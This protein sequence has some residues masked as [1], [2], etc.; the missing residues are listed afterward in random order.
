MT[1]SLNPLYLI[2]LAFLGCNSPDESF[3]NGIADA[4]EFLRKEDEM[5]RKEYILSYQAAL[6]SDRNLQHR[7]AYL[8]L[9]S[10]ITSSSHYMDSIYGE[11]SFQA[12]HNPTNFEY[13]KILFLYKGVGDSIFAGLT[14][15]NDLARTIALQT[16]HLSITD[17]LKLTVLSEPV[18]S[19]WKE[20]YFSELNPVSAMAF[21]HDFTCEVF[22]VGKACL[23]NP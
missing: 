8:H 21:V 6:R 16:C 7:K 20:R 23:P 19:A 14:R 22:Q 10:A 17:S 12:D 15:V 9:D 13:V 18:A 5:V 3:R 11:M 4:K 1:K 2:F